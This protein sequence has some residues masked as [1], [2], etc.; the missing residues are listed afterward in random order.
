MERIRMKQSK[1]SAGQPRPG[2]TPSTPRLQPH[3]QQHQYRKHLQ[4]QQRARSSSPP[5]FG[6]LPPAQP[7]QHRHR[8]R[9]RQWMGSQAER[10]EGTPSRAGPKSGHMRIRGRSSPSSIPPSTPSTPY[11]TLPIHRRPHPPT[12]PS[13][14]QHHRIRLVPGQEQGQGQGRA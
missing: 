12:L 10:E 4:H 3:L 2:F 14:P 9:H 1:P 11:T 13:S 8:H 7:P 6:Q 5:G